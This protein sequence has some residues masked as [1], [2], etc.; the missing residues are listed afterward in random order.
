MEGG[1][2]ELVLVR[3]RGSRE[4]VREKAPEPLG[5]LAPDEEL[6]AV[7]VSA[8]PGLDRLDGRLGARAFG[9]LPAAAALV[10]PDLARRDAVVAV[11]RARGLGPG[12]ARGG[13]ARG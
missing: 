7:G 9:A 3:A 2:K 5:E 1:E 8:R 10:P 13:G 12:G 6:E 11:R 4:R